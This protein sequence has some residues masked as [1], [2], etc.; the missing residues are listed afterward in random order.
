MED[1][2][3]A[4]GEPGVP[5][6]VDKRDAV[7]FDVGRVF[8]QSGEEF[9]KVH[10]CERGPSVSDTFVKDHRKKKYRSKECICGCFPPLKAPSKLPGRFDDWQKD[11]RDLQIL[12]E[13]VAVTE[14]ALVSSDVNGLWGPNSRQSQSQSGKQNCVIS[15]T[16][17]E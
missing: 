15:D 10:R 6:K 8:L 17:G 12:Q 1:F 9:A 2:L 13:L 4:G 16:P 5:L 3:D 11:P 14:E 7:D